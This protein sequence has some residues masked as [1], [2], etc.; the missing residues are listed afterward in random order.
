MKRPVILCADDFAQS[1]GISQGI[2]ALIDAGRL[3]A[4]SVFSESPHWH[5][6]APAL[7]ARAVDAGLHL[8]LTEPFRPGTRGLGA[9]LVL[10]QL[11]LL[12]QQALLGRIL[13]QVDAFAEAMG[14]LPDYLDGHQHV[15]G[16]PVVRD[17]LLQAIA[18]RWPPETRPYLRRPDRLADGGD[19]V[20]KARVLQ[21]CCR[22]FSASLRPHGLQGPDWFAGLYSLTPGADFPRLMRGWLGRAPAGGLIMCHPGLPDAAPDPIAAT[23]PLEL[24]YLASDAFV[25]D[26]HRLGVVIARYA[27]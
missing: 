15:H 21:A 7:A 17:A 10:S 12:S 9:W 20:F 16:L 26:C 23:R 8:N 5:A 4:T 27:P 18:L 2:L 3:S 11:R 14:R 1:P 22:G 13:A 24:A 6:L 25:D 19:S